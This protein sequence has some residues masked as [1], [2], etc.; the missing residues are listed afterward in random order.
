MQTSEYTKWEMIAKRMKMYKNYV[1]YSIS[2][3]PHWL[4]LFIQ[5]S[6]C[7]SELFDLHERLFTLQAKGT[8]N[9]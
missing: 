8:K 4:K 1:T 2:S 7:F 3:Q 9:S 5:E 6:Y